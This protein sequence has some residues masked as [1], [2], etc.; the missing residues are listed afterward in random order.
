MK[1]QDNTIKKSN[2]IC[3]L[4]GKGGCGKT[5]TALIFS[6]LLAACGKKVLLVDCDLATQGASCF[7]H[8]QVISRIRNNEEIAF[9]N[10]IIEVPDSSDFDYKIIGSED[11]AVDKIVKIAD[12]YFLPYDIRKKEKCQKVSYTEN[13]KKIINQCLN[14][15]F[16]VIIFDCQAGYNLMSQELVSISDSVLFMNENDVVSETAMELIQGRLIDETMTKQRYHILNKC[17]DSK[18]KERKSNNQLLQHTSPI[19][20]NKE[21]GIGFTDVQFMNLDFTKSSFWCPEYLLDIVRTAKECF[22]EYVQ[23]IAL[24]ERTIKKYLYKNNFLWAAALVISGT[25]IALFIILAIFTSF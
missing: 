11:N 17:V 4:S 22:P 23:E 5:T 21:V 16:D 6:K 10:K 9:F 20:F 25:I 18:E 2:K 8:N 24:K 14:K 12:I 1:N 7:L 15:N 19:M 13:L 3:I